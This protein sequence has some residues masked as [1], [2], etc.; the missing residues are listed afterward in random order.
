MCPSRDPETPLL[1]KHSSEALAFMHHETNKKVLTS[2]VY[3]HL[4]QL[5]GEWCNQQWYV[6]SVEYYICSKKLTTAICIKVHKSYQH[7]AE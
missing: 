4:Y 5:I 7:N 2:S 3:T 1:D 6:E